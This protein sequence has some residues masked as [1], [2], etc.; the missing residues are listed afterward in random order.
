MPFKPYDQCMVQFDEQYYMLIAHDRQSKPKRNRYLIFDLFAQ[1]WLPEGQDTAFTNE[2][3]MSNQFFC[4]AFKVDGKT[5]VFMSG[6][7]YSTFLYDVASR[8][9]TK[10]K[11]K[12]AVR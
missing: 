6:I 4:D 8:E 2:G 5:K 12:V 11:F 7:G 10:G 1:K 9:W 3:G